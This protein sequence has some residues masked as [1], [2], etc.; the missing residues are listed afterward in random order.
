MDQQFWASV[1]ITQ[2]A[3]GQSCPVYDIILCE[4]L[5]GGA[6]GTRDKH[7]AAAGRR[8]QVRR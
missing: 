6:S 1:H 4:C 5:P 7:K 2:Q 8:A 3:E